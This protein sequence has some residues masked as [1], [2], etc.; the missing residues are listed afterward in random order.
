MTKD[1]GGA[2]ERQGRIPSN[3]SPRR[4]AIQKPK[5][6][7]RI[8]VLARESLKKVTPIEFPESRNEY[9]FGAGQIGFPFVATIFV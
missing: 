9:I 1:R 7:D 5:K 8:Y 3:T 6:D 4:E 2:R